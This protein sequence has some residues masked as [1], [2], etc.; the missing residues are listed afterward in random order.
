[1]FKVIGI[2]AV[3]EVKLFNLHQHIRYGQVYIDV[4]HVTIILVLVY[5]IR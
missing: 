4:N 5:A 2:E 1:M 3:D